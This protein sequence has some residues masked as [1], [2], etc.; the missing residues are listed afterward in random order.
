MG[1]SPELCSIYIIQYSTVVTAQDE[2]FTERS[3]SVGLEL[4]Y[5]F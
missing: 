2:I 3:Q 4:D 1:L 5:S